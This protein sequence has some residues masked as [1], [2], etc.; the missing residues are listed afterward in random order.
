MEPKAGETDNTLVKFLE[1]EAAKS[2]DYQKLTTVLIYM[3]IGL[4]VIGVAV[5][6]IIVNK[7][8][9]PPSQVL[10]KLENADAKILSIDQE[11]RLLTAEVQKIT[12]YIEGRNSQPEE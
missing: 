9:V 8:N 12:F 5:N 4:T 11:V 10:Q 1:Y 2:V 6:L 7:L 3:L